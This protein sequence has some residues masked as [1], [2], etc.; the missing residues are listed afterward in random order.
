MFPDSADDLDEEPL[1]GNTLYPD[2]QRRNVTL[3]F[4][5]PLFNF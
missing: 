5:R 1:T 3:I 4:V 2:G